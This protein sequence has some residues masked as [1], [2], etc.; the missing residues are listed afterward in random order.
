MCVY[1]HLSGKSEE[2][3]AQMCDGIVKTCP[4]T[5]RSSVYQKYG[6]K[7]KESWLSTKV[8]VTPKRPAKVPNLSSFPH[9]SYKDG[10]R[11][12][13]LIGSKNKRKGRVC[14]CAMIAYR[15]LFV[16]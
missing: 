7:A 4:R 5:V 16:Q 13:T 2:S 12:L 11:G 8:N 14:I 1:V 6:F 10:E 15:V 3:E 9:H